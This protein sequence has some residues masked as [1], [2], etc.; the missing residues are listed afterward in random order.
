MAAKTQQGPRE[1]PPKYARLNLAGLKHYWPPANAIYLRHKVK[2]GKDESFETIA[3]RYNVPVEKLIEFNF[4]GSVDHHGH[5]VPE[6]VNWYLHHHRGFFGGPVT[7][8]GHNRIFRGHEEVA[9]PFPG[10]VQNRLPTNLK[11]PPGP[12]GVG[13]RRYGTLYT[14]GVSGGPPPVPPGPF[15]E[16][17]ISGYSYRQDRVIGWSP[18]GPKSGPVIAYLAIDALQSDPNRF[19]PFQVLGY[20]GE[21]EIVLGSTYDLTNRP[22]SILPLPPGRFPVR[23]TEV[24]PT[25]FTFTTLPGHFDYDARSPGGS[26]VTFSTRSDTAGAVHLEQVGVARTHDTSV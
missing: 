14:N 19:F 6:I 21:R 7:H 12:L 10:N 8:D 18:H 15:T 26:T 3:A 2:S 13:N 16:S 4:P 11:V 5:V 20:N 1:H 9:I 24:T 25:S 23:V 17:T 22:G